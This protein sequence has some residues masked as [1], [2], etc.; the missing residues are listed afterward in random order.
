M[1]ILVVDDEKSIRWLLSDALTS[2]GFEVIE[3]KDGQESLEKMETMDFDLIITDIDMPRL[4]GIAM[5]REMET[6][7][8]KEKVIIM[9]GNTA[10]HGT[11]FSD[12]PRVV[13]HLP[14]PFE[15]GGLVDLVMDATAD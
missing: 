7:G 14:K 1:K 6:A 8:R 15:I 11:V 5:L 12:I 10:T 9:S 3:A 13:T 2:K 4:D